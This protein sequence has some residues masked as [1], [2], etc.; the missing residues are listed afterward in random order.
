MF[1]GKEAVRL[2][3]PSL[4]LVGKANVN[5][6]NNNDPLVSKHWT[7]AASAWVP[8]S[9]EAKNNGPSL[10][11][12]GSGCRGEGQLSG[13]GK[14]MAYDRHRSGLWF[15]LNSGEFKWGPGCD[16]PSP[17][18]EDVIGDPVWQQKPPSLLCV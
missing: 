1:R 5:G 15:T 17:T 18:S 7:F 10:F 11:L 16:C 8:G 14:A 6:G 9:S 3:S 4:M 13:E 2:G 12:R